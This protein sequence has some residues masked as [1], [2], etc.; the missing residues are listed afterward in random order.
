MGIGALL[1][2]CERVVGCDID[3]KAP[4]AAMANAALNGIGEDRLKVYAGDILSD[5]GM[6]SFLGTG[7]EIVLANIVADV[8]LPLS[9]FVRRFM[10]QDGIF[11]C[12]G[13]IDDRAAEVEKSLISNGFRVLEH[14]HEEEWHAFVCQ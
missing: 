3:P 8:I 13:I 6:R 5:E 14:L 2:G 9:A 10:A 4:D 12:S 7:Y 1:L 11:I